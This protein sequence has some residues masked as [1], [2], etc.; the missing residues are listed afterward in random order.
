M[1]RIVYNQL[2]AFA[3][4]FLAACGG[5]G[6]DGGGG[7]PPVV[8]PPV[9]YTYSVPDDIGDGWAVS[10]LADENMDEAPIATM[11][12]RILDGTYPGIDAVAIARNNKLVLHQQIRTG[13]GQFDAWAGNTDPERH[14]LHSTSKSVTSALIGIAIDQGHIASTQVPFYDLFNY[15]AYDNWDPRKADMTLEDALTMRLG[16]EWDEWSL[17]YTNPEND[18]V[19]LENNN[20][21][22]PKA[23]LDLPM[24]S[25]P[26]TVFAYNTAATIAIGQALVN[27]TGIPMDIYADQYLFHP[28]GIFDALWAR[29]PAGLPIGGS[30]LYL[31]IRDQLKFGQLFVNDGV[32]DGQQLISAAWI[33]DSVTPRVDISSWA[34]YSEAYGFQWWLDTFNFRQQ[35][36][37][38][39]VTAGYGGQYTFCFP[40]LN[41]VVAFTGR[42]Y[43]NPNGVTRLYEMVQD[44][45][46]AS[47]NQ[48]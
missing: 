11:L 46:I 29:S 19:D 37:E 38:A 8:N 4:L 17:P 6:A 23:L 35:G 7:V 30:G 48:P 42:N 33:A 16:L 27:A 44:F 43:T 2:V 9:Q 34:T 28:M 14:I 5:G 45:V 12:Q 39:W 41:L 3:L 36:A 47:V 10:S 25:D 22:W 40:D 31:K 32:W 21:D 26:G 24:T 1:R 13:T 15:G 18:L 20:T